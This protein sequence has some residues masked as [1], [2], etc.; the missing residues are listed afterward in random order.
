MVKKKFATIKTPRKEKKVMEIYNTK[1]IFSRVPYLNSTHKIKI[2]DLFSYE[3][4]PI[5]TVLFKYTSEGRYPTSKADMK[6][7][8]KVEVLVRNIIPEA[9]MIDGCAMMHSNLHCPKSG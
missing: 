5:P 9:T 6:N 1:V 2:N 8:L 7:V 4:L 3:L